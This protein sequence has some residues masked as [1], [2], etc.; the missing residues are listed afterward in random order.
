LINFEEIK[1]VAMNPNNLEA[2]FEFLMNQ[3]KLD[4]AQVSSK[5]RE[6]FECDLGFNA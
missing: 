2:I 6:Y 1:H 4:N 5:S 3:L